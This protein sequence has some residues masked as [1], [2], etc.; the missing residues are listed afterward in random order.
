VLDDGHPHTLGFLGAI[1]GIPIACLGV[2]DLGQSVDVDDLYRHFGIDTD[3]FVGAA[4][5]LLQARRIMTD[6]TMPKLSMP[7]NR[8]HAFPRRP[9]ARSH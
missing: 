4:V 5:D 6:I 8:A 2:G 1:R 7:R 3:T 9:F